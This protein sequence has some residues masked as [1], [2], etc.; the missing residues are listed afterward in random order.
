MMRN[1]TG[2]IF[3]SAILLA[4][5]F[6]SGCGGY[7]VLTVPDQVAPVDGKAVATVRLQRNDFLVLVLP[8]KGQPMR[9]SIQDP[10]ADSGSGGRGREMSAQTDLEGYAGV[11]FSMSAPPVNG[12]PGVYTLE[13]RLQDMYGDRLKRRSRLFVWDPQQHLIAVE[14]DA[15]PMFGSGKEKATAALRRAKR[16]ANIVYL[17]EHSMRDYESQHNLLAEA[18]YPDGPI[19]LWQYRRWRMKKVGSLGVTIITFDPSLRG[20]LQLLLKDFPNLKTGVCSS[21]EA[22]EAFLEAGLDPIVIGFGFA[23][24]DW[25]KLKL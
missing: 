5:G 11:P 9:F 14:M 3:C 17:T 24:D 10:G 21:S 4:G 8:E 15:L 1:I 18:G 20:N 16:K 13:V 19:L 23:E 22:R 2:V 25:S 7:Y 12:K 6:L